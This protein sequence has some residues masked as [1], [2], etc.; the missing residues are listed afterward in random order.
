[1]KIELEVSDIER[2]RKARMAFSAEG[3][4]TQPKRPYVP[5]PLFNI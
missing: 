3:D 1:M 2:K 4:D 5:F